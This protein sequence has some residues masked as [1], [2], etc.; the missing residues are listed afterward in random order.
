MKKLFY[1]VAV[2]LAL[3]GVAFAQTAELEP[4]PK[5]AYENHVSAWHGGQL[6]PTPVRAVVY[7]CLTADPYAD[8]TETRAIFW[9]AMLPEQARTA[10]HSAFYSGD[11]MALPQFRTHRMDTPEFVTFFS[12]RQ[13]AIES[14]RPPPVWT[15]KRNA[16]SA[17]RPVYA[18]ST[19][20]SGVVTLGARVAGVTAPVGSGCYCGSPY[21][22]YTNST[23]TYCL[24]TRSADAFRRRVIDIDRVTI[25]EKVR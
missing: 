16:D 18:V 13:A 14:K 4:A 11:T 15:V 8:Y 5:C 9:P 17:V 23:S 22:R 1:A 7:W 10:L 24:F 19:S 2:A 25:C 3:C 6:Q 20:A 21:W 12:T